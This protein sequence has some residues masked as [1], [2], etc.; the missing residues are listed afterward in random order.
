MFTPYESAQA[1]FLRACGTVARI[2]GIEFVR[3]RGLNVNPNHIRLVENLIVGREVLFRLS[4]SLIQLNFVN[5]TNGR[6]FTRIALCCRS[7]TSSD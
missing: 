7:L 2:R 4:V 5:M 3:F 1:P 6:A